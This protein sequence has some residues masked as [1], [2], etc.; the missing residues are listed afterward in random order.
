MPG[1]QPKG[2]ALEAYRVSQY[3]SVKANVNDKDEKMRLQKPRA[4]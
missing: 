2:S 3:V 4:K 1:R